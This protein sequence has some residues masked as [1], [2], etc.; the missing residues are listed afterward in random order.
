MHA[1]LLPLPSGLLR[2]GSRCEIDDKPTNKLY[3]TSPELQEQ[4]LSN[5]TLP[6][7]RARPPPDAGMD[8]ALVKDPSRASGSR[9]FWETEE[10][11]EAARPSPAVYVYELPRFVSHGL[12]WSEGV[13]G[14]FGR[15]LVRRRPRHMQ[16]TLPVGGGYYFDVC[17]ADRAL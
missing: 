3:T 14:D 1:G 2:C 12:A 11:R 5:L 9:L 17:Q 4:T 16:N 13:G 10:E 8:C 7:I 6:L 15:C